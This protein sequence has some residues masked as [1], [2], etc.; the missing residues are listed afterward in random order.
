MRRN[1]EYCYFFHLFVLVFLRKGRCK[2]I[3]QKLPE[4]EL[5]SPALQQKN[6]PE[7]AGNSGKQLHPSQEE[8]SKHFP[9]HNADTAIQISSFNAMPPPDF[10]SGGGQGIHG[11]PER[12]HARQNSG[13]QPQIRL[14]ATKAGPPIFIPFAI[15]LVSA[16]N[17]SQAN[18]VKTSIE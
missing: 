5:P 16:A 18:V 14:F 2:G 9:D 7:Q 15:S 1:T 12:P 17:K 6:R 10:A 13:L 8:K 3:Q 4:A 11:F